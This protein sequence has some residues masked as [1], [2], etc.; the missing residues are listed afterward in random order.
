MQLSGIRNEG[1]P[2]PNRRTVQPGRA[3]TK[4]IWARILA[5]QA[6]P[7]LQPEWRQ[8]GSACLYSSATGHK[9]YR[10]TGLFVML[11]LRAVPFL[12]LAGFGLSPAASGS[13]GAHAAGVAGTDS[14][15]ITGQATR[16]DQQTLAG[17]DLPGMRTLQPLTEIA[18]QPAAGDNII[19]EIEAKGFSKITGLMRRGENY[20]F[21]AFDPFGMKVRVVMNAR[22]GEIVGLSRIT[23]RKK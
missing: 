18:Q 7:G 14:L 15:P 23:P 8:K 6:R 16:L 4:S 5:V 19:R 3:C 9:G 20:V 22:T 10:K 12:L 21:Q 11:F 13:A 1:L 2:Q 17:L